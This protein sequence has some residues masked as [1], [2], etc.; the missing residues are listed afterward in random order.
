MF[1]P[2]AKATEGTGVLYVYV[3]T[4]GSTEAPRGG[5]NGDTYFVSI[6]TTYYIR[7]FEITEFD[8][9]DIL[10][11]KIGWTN[12]SG[13]GQTTVFNNVL[14]KESGGVEHVDVAWTVPSN[15]KV[16]TTATVH[17]TQKPGPDYIASGQVSNIGHMHI[18]TETFLGTIGAILALFVG[19]GLY[20]LPKKNKPLP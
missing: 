5:P 3:D 7:V 6:G 1:I 19:F 13:L 16:C 8:K 15:T 20:L 18:I 9:G 4:W 17:Y 12:S 11:V 10:Q 14:V 2:F